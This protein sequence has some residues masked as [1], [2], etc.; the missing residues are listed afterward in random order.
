MH[1][2]F[3]YVCQS[4]HVCQPVPALAQRSDKLSVEMLLMV[5]NPIRR[6]P[7]NLLQAEIAC[8]NETY[9]GTN[10]YGD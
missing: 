1:G 3:C 9:N 7:K 5:W 2:G 10:M 4:V 8:P 6:N